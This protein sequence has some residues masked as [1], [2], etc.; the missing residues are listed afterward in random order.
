MVAIESGEKRRIPP[1]VGPRSITVG[2][3]KNNTSIFFICKYCKY[4]CC[5]ICTHTCMLLQFY[6]VGQQNRT[7][8]TTRCFFSRINDDDSVLLIDVQV[9]LAER[10]AALSRTSLN[11]WRRVFTVSVVSVSSSVQA[12]DSNGSRMMRV[13]ESREQSPAAVDTCQPTDDEM[14]RF[15]PYLCSTEQIWSQ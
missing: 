15:L 9:I 13:S 11:V 1:T 2:N 3:L 5:L 14:L 4:C 6:M 8:L 7:I 12:E 10:T